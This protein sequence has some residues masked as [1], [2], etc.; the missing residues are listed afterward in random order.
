MDFENGFQGKQDGKFIINK[1]DATFHEGSRG[2]KARRSA[3][4]QMR[5]ASH[6]L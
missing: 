3:V 4:I 2:S 5:E 6:G 1:E